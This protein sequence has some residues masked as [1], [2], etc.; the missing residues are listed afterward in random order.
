MNRKNS[1]FWGVMI[2][3]TCIFFYLMAPI[4]KSP[5]IGIVV[6]QVG[7]QWVIKDFVNT[8]M[9]GHSSIKREDIVLE[10]NHQPIK[11]I[12]GATRYTINRANSLMIQDV[13][14]KKR[15]V[16]MTY[17]DFWAQWLYH[18]ALPTCYFIISLIICVYLFFK[19]KDSFYS[20]NIFM[21]FILTVALEFGSIGATI[22]N[23]SVGKFIS[24][25]GG[26]AILVLMLHFFINYLE[27]LNLKYVLI[28]K[29]YY[30]YG[31]LIMSSILTL[32]EKV[33]PT[34]Y[35]WNTMVLLVMMVF[36]VIYAL[37]ILLVAYIKTK[38]QQLLVLLLC[39]VGPFIPALVLYVLPMLLFG[40]YI[41]TAINCLLFLLLIPIL[42]LLTQFSDYLFDIEYEISKIRY[43]SMLSFATSS[44]LSIGLYFLLDLQSL[45]A[46][47]S[48]LFVFVVTLGML[49]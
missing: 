42:L 34:I 5:F 10:V 17:R 26:I 12:G 28:I 35:Q 45:D 37:L 31:L 36:L 8:G 21:L 43:Y 30:L 23:D 27:Y 44:M 19:R 39:L 1:V 24:S 48:F 40:Q 6:E 29:P 47:K 9:I 20:F 46:F 33:F 41:L 16:E 11:E 13:E 14:G 15:L 38:K 32:L 18:I 49:I 3:Y 4:I 22:H 25:N 7:Q 2:V